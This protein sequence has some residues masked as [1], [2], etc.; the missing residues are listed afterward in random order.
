MNYVEVARLT[1]ETAS[2]SWVAP[3]HI[4]RVVGVLISAGWQVAVVNLAS[5]LSCHAELSL[6]VVN[7]ILNSSYGLAWESGLLNLHGESSQLSKLIV[8]R[9]LLLLLLFVRFQIWCIHI[10]PELS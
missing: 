10:A 5:H 3:T 6:V 1:I 2:V 8:D 7:D 9:A 4:V